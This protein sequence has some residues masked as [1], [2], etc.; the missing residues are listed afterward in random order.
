MMGVKMMK[1]EEL[2]KLVEARNEAASKFIKAMA[3]L[4]GALG[5]DA[6]LQ[7]P[8]LTSLELTNRNLRLD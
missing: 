5:V 4:I 7:A 1:V 8:R 6:R 2:Q 3:E